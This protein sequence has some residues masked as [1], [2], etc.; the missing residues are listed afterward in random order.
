ME[1]YVRDF[2]VFSYFGVSF[3]ELKNNREEAIKRCAHRAYRDLNRTLVFYKDPEDS[4]EKRKSFCD[5]IAE[6]ISQLTPELITNKEQFDCRHH[7][8]CSAIVSCANSTD[9]L[10]DIP[11]SNNNPQKKCYPFYYGQAQKW[12]NMTLKY[13]YLLGLWE[14]DFSKIKSKLHVPVD[15]YILKIAAGGKNSAA[16]ESKYWLN[17]KAPRNHDHDVTKKISC[18]EIVHALEKIE[19]IIPFGSYS[20]GDRSIP[21]SKWSDADYLLFI[22]KL[23]SSFDD[24]KKMHEQFSHWDLFDREHHAWI[25]QASLEK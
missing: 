3:E 13:M 24:W 1:K 2:Y 9:I 14:R 18:D 16:A 15:K 21:W 25:A 19:K 5:T 4:E 6:R 8:L 20:D 7:H 17:G 11:A 23:R 10:K 12:V 22:R